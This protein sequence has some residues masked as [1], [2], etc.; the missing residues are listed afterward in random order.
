MCQ[1]IFSGAAKNKQYLRKIGI[2]HVLNTAEGNKFGMVNTSKEYYRDTNIK[3][4]GVQLLDLPVTNIS[5][6]FAET[7][8]FIESGVKSGGNYYK[9]PICIKRVE[10]SSVTLYQLHF[11]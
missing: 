10:V 6:H 7:A 8:D 9:F 11:V 2:T 3:Y 4:M 1:F 5:A